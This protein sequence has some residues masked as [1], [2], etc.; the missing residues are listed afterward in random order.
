MVVKMKRY[1]KIYQ[2]F[3][4]Q[5]LKQLLQYRMDFLI[6]AGSF[7]FIQAS[8]VLF[9]T[10]VFTQIPSL[11][12][13]TLDKMIFLY[14]FF[15]LPR[16]IDHLFTDNIWMIPSK[17]RRGDIDRYLVRPINP[18]FQCIAE[19]FQP[20]AFGELIVGVILIAYT[21]DKV[22]ITLNLLT[23]G[24]MLIYVIMGS[25]IYTGIKLITASVGFW[26]MNSMP[27]MTS[28]YNI[29]DFSKYPIVIFP[30]V[31]QII[32]TYVIPFGFV[33]F[34]PANSILNHSSSM[35]VLMGSSVALILLWIV[36]YR[37]WLYG[38]KSY[39]SVGS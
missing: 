3:L 22:G 6:G 39:Q 7:L 13:W 1:L 37:L 27:L 8:G 36:A 23:L 26:A 31:V 25:M 11:N 34:F 28:V 16:G 18:L 38:L 17:V 24:M 12:G 32:I 10:L 29:A 35:D 5:Y 15:Q 2:V 20:E 14:G 19:R 9:I 21:L 30:K 4:F 33:S